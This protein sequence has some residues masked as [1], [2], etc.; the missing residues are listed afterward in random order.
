MT[1]ALIRF[2]CGLFHRPG[3]LLRCVLDGLS[4]I[5]KWWNP[6][7]SFGVPASCGFLG[8]G[9]ICL[10]FCSVLFC[11]VE[12]HGGRHLRLLVSNLPPHNKDIGD[13]EAGSIRGGKHVKHLAQRYDYL[14]STSF[15]KL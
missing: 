6:N 15:I 11:S 14:G 1:L 5:F 8:F 13:A 4:Q 3:C 7:T 2:G 10:L 12:L 9:S